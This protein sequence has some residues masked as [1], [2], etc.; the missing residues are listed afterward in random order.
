MSDASRLKQSFGLSEAEEQH[1]DEEA[2]RAPTVGSLRMERFTQEFEALQ[3]RI[4]LRNHGNSIRRRVR[5]VIRDKQ[6][7]E[8]LV[9]ELAHFTSKLSQIMPIYSDGTLT[10]NVADEDVESIRDIRMLKIVHDASMG[11][12]KAITDSAQR[13][14]TRNCQDRILAILWFRAMDDREASIS[15]PHNKTMQ[16]ALQPPQNDVPWDDFSKW[17]TEGS[18]IYWISGKAGSG[19]STLMKY[20]FHHPETRALVSRWAGGASYSL[21]P[22]FFWNLGTSNQKSQEGLARTLLFRILSIHRTLIAEALPNMWKELYDRDD[23]SLPSVAETRYAFQT[24]ATRAST[25]SKFC[26][27]IDGLDEYVGDYRDG[28]AFIRQCVDNTCRHP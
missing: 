22:F 4:K 26:L 6:K 2:E 23:A 1:N 7:F 19:K 17:L 21:I 16:W 3:L 18:G 5:W 11:H 15:L 13:S 9:K 27:F 25:L 28:I 8:N 20:L 12:N 24:I 14:I 10:Q